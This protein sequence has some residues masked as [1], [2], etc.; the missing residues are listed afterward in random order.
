MGNKKKKNSDR[1]RR[2]IAGLLSAVSLYSGVGTTI[3][4]VNAADIPKT[5]YSEHQDDEVNIPEDLRYSIASA[6]G[7]RTDEP[8]TID[9]LKSLTYQTLVLENDIEYDLSYLQYCTNLDM[10]VIMSKNTDSSVL[11]TLPPLP[12]LKSLII[13]SIA[14][15]DYGDIIDLD[16]SSGIGFIDN[17]PTLKN[18]TLQ[19]VSLPVECEEQLNKLDT[20]SL[21]IESTCDI[22]FELLTNLKCLDVSFTDPYNLAIFLNTKEYQ[23]LLNA[24][25]EIKFKNEE[26]KEKYLN[27]NQKLDNIISSLEIDETSTDTEKLNAI[28]IYVLEN[29]EYSERM[30]ELN[31]QLK[32]TSSQEERILIEKEKAEIR[33][34]VY[35]DGMLYGA[36]ESNEAICGNYAAL[37][38]ALMDRLKISKES[39]ILK[40]N[41]HA[42]NLIIIDGQP[43]Y[44]DATWLEDKTAYK[45]SVKEYINEEGFHVVETS[46]TP[47]LPE[48][49]IRSGITDEL[50]WYKEN[51]D[52]E[53]ISSID[54][55][56]SHVPIYTPAYMP[57]QN[58][59]YDTPPVEYEVP[60]ENN[61]Q[62]SEEPPIISET[63][64][65]ERSQEEVTVEV[66]GK[67]KKIK[68]GA[69]IGILVALGGAVPASIIISKKKRE[70]RRRKNF[71]DYGQ[72]DYSYDPYSDDSYRRYR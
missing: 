20:L 29:L 54:Q 51:P 16:L 37:V 5:S 53:H 39:T 2:Y 38:E 47:I 55:S 70:K 8:I 59:L 48:E 43:Y 57:T 31:E 49:A 14:W 30:I 26:Q 23:T 13:S 11:K 61:Q 4:H 69:L 19:N 72:Y 10:L 1:T 17:Y 62:N 25:V 42:W 33:K 9:D 46:Y 15:S 32:E 21:M 3:G 67:Q 44:V 27:A 50:N 7:K 24:G 60:E 6:V 58:T 40:S 34:T 52:P 56:E 66:N 22:N 35:Q 45:E 64:E 41:T 28:L 18:L 36:L 71:Y 68:M 12:N 65:N 63:L